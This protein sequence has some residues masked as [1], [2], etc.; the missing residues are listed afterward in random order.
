MSRRF[1]SLLPLL[2]LAAATPACAEQEGQ[3]WLQQT[4]T[5]DL[6][7][8]GDRMLIELNERFRSERFGG[9]QYQATML[10]SRPIA[11]GLRAGAGVSYV[12]TGGDDE[13]RLMT[14][15]DYR[16]GVLSLRGRMEARIRAGR[17]I[18]LRARPRAGVAV[19]L[20]VADLTAVANH[21]LFFTLNEGRPGD[22]TGLTSMRSIAALQR[23]FSDTLT[24]GVGYLRQQDV[25]R[26]AADR[27]GNAGY[28]SLAVSF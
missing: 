26:N 1:R 4:A 28:V 10:F 2:L 13:G 6:G 17:D 15:L 5:T 25:R 8:D 19:P 24:V 14:Q 7:D 3:L 22:A 20:G 18:V 11:E 12:N 27:I 16:R 21:E 23:K 9:D